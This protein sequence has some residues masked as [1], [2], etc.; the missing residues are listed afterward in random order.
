MIFTQILLS[1]LVGL[2]TSAYATS[3]MVRAELRLAIGWR[4]VVSAILGSM[5]MFAT[6]ECSTLLIQG[7]SL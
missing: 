2:I 4:R 3:V 6:W 7:W 5:A 1:A